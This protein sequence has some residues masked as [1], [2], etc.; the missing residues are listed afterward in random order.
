MP[1]VIMFFCERPAGVGGQTPVAD[2]RKI[3]AGLKD[4]VRRRFTEKKVQ[5]INNLHG[6]EG[7]GRSWQEAFETQDRGVVEQRLREDGYAFTWKPDGS[8]RTSIVCDAVGTHPETGEAAWINQAEQW[9]PSGLEPKTRRT[10]K[11]LMSEEDFPHNATFGDGSLLPEADLQ[12]I[13]EVMSAEEKVFEWQGGDVLVCDNI[14]VAHGRQPYEGE[15]RVLVS[16]A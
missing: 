6:G 8:L 14:L 10:L 12:H 11:M 9:H 15:R 1:R 7:V 5:Y 2:C 3:L 13:R 16:L 4:D